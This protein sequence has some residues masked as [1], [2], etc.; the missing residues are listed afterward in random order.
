MRAVL[1]DRYG[2]PEALRL[3]TTG[4]PDLRAD[5]VLVRVRATSVHVDAWHVV[6]GLP[7]ALRLMGA[8]VLRPR[9][10]VPGTDVAGV[11]EAVGAA[12]SRF[13][14]GQAV[15]GETVRGIQWRNGGAWAELVAAPEDG[16]VLVPTGL[17]FEQAAAVG[18]PAVLAYEVLVDQAGFRAGQSLLVNGAAGAMGLWVVQ[19]ALA[20]GASRVVG[21][22]HPDKLALLRSVGV[23]EVVDFTRQDPTRLERPVDVVIDVASTR[24]FAEWRRVLTPDGT[25]VTVGHDRFGE[26]MNRWT[27]SIGRVLRMGLAGPFRRQLPGLRR[28]T[29]RADRLAHIAHMLEAGTVRPVV[30]RTYPLADTVEALTYLTSGRA[31][32]RVVL[33]P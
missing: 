32:G 33:V 5:E 8:G 29:P 9:T 16:L 6:V 13:H 12:V 11:V 17:D 1:Q 21:V 27:G 31:V 19:L 18:T 28:S 15:M 23:E 4:I 30:D 24:T 26:G 2:P 10:P 20:L 14:P 22:D 25:F 7:Y 3:G